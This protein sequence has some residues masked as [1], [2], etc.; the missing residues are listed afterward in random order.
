M[1]CW[2]C[3]Q[4]SKLERHTRMV[5]CELA[6]LGEAQR[7][8]LALEERQQV[9]SEELLLEILLEKIEEE[10]FALAAGYARGLDSPAQPS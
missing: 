6:D 4:A 8:V 5:E 7:Y 2:R 3:E 10:R 9:E 1:S